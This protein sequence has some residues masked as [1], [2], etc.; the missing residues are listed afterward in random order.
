MLEVCS[1]RITAPVGIPSGGRK[2]AYCLRVT[3]KNEQHDLVGRP[4][5]DAC[6]CDCNNIDHMQ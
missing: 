6:S 5:G 1:G 3:R 4:T 2:E